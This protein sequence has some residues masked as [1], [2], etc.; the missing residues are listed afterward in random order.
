MITGTSKFKK[1]F[2]SLMAV[3]ALASSAFAV[4]C[5]DLS[6][7]IKNFEARNNVILTDSNNSIYI[8]SSE[9]TEF[10]GF[11]GNS[12][13]IRINYSD[14]IQSNTGELI[15]KLDAS[16]DLKLKNDLYAH[17][18]SNSPYSGSWGFDSN[19]ADCNFTV[20]VEVETVIADSELMSQIANLENTNSNLISTNQSLTTTIED[21]KTVLE[22]VAPAGETWNINTGA[23]ETL[24]VYDR[25]F[26]ND[27]FNNPVCTS[28]QLVPARVDYYNGAECLSLCPNID[29]NTTDEN[30]LSV[31]Y[32]TTQI[33]DNLGNCI[34]TPRNSKF[35]IHSDGV[36]VFEYMKG[37]LGKEKYYN[38]YIANARPNGKVIVNTSSGLKFKM[39][40]LYEN[41]TTF[42]DYDFVT[43]KK[44][45]LKGYGEYED[46]NFK[47]NLEYQLNLGKFTAKG[48]ITAKK[49][50]TD[51]LN[52]IYNTWQSVDYNSTSKK[53]I[54]GGLIYQLKEKANKKL[55]TQFK[56]KDNLGF[57]FQA[58][59][60]SGDFNFKKV[61]FKD[62]YKEDTISQ[63]LNLN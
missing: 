19:G 35:Y 14:D 34:A 44:A 6:N 32:T 59:T 33:R 42:A 22:I 60:E 62:T 2:L 28:G 51:R 54:N 37:K 12:N 36:V 58:Y 7:M 13:M 23:F 27:G 52:S 46:N 21:Y 5:I 11:D 15:L 26:S 8:S 40:S 16:A 17:F 30:N 43:D 63:D 41:N 1:G 50:L 55:L 4:D 25:N 31:N 3:S 47:G 56:Y 29:V 20:E 45:K 61:Y 48:Y 18:V 53:F 39:N 24:D 49:G 38:S 57:Q 10:G 9:R